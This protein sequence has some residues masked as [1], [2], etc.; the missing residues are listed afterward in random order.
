MPAHKKPAY[1]L[2]LNRYKLR[3]EDL[4]RELQ[5]RLTLHTRKHH[6]EPHSPE[7]YAGAEK[8]AQAIEDWYE[9]DEEEEA[10]PPAP[11]PEPP[12]PAPPQEPTGNEAVL[13][14]LFERG[15]R[16]LTVSQL[17]HAGFEGKPAAGT[18]GAYQLKKPTLAITFTLSRLS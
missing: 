4:P 11:E 15:F 6:Q 8:I 13:A 17:K 10:P 1:E 9:A 12:A 2:V 3:F 18:Y 5:A 7:A 16:S 14:T